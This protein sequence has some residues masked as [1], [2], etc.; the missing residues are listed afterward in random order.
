MTLTFSCTPE[1][2][3]WVRPKVGKEEDLPGYTFEVLINIL[4]W[5]CMIIRSDWSF[6]PQTRDC[7]FIIWKIRLAE[8]F[9]QGQKKNWNIEGAWR[10]W[11]HNL[12]GKLHCFMLVLYR[13]QIIQ[14]T[15]YSF[16]SFLVDCLPTQNEST[17]SSSFALKDQY[18]SQTSFHRNPLET[19]NYLS[20]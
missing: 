3:A 9:T 11:R 7:L 10:N 13:V 17:F 6:N 15:S 12:K 14:W 19:H 16:I 18:L 20:L 8:G 4:N 1:S 5:S 2:H